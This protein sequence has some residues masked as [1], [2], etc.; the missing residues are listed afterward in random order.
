MLKTIISLIRVFLI[1][2]FTLI[3]SLVALFINLIDRSFGLYFWL[4]RKFARGSLFIAGAK[5]NITGVENIE[6]GKVYV[7][8]SN[9]SSMFD[10][11]VIMGTVPNKASIVFKKELSRIPVFGW[12]LVT[13]P[14]IMIDRTHPEKAMRS[15]EKGKKM[16]EEKRISVILFAE[17][18]RSKTDEVQPFK[19]GAF[20]LASK[21][22]FPI[23][24]VS[25][26]GASSLLPKG[27]LALQKG[28]INIHFGE[29]IDTS[30][31]HSKKDEIELMEIVRN[32][33]I[34][35]MVKK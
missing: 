30:H 33:V 12:Q 25:I 14:Y 29:A 26:S 22:K 9:H 7:Y 10:I 11:P 27:S 28:T 35:N 23:I 17:G 8:V 34:K 6:K 13:G 2:A 19:R 20:Y 4:S 18:T 32:T 5:L 21:V 1:G 3:M 31:L 24:P 15:I 16:M